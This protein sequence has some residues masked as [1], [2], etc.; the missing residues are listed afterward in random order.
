MGDRYD[1]RHRGK[2][3]RT[4]EKWWPIP[5]DR[6]RLWCQVL[7]DF[8]PIW[9]GTFPMIHTRQRVLEGGHTNIT[10]WADLAVRAEV[11][12]FTPLTWLIFRQD[13]G[14][15]TLVAE[16]PDHPEHRQKVMG[17][18]GVERTIVD[19]EEFRAWPRLFAAGYR[20]SEATWMILA[21]QVPEEFAW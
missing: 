18:H 21:G 8:P 14:R 4:E 9:Y 16:F 15:N 11:A 20:A 12:G 1:G 2:K 13:L 10:E 19:P 17:N 5:P 3:K 7:L 6:R